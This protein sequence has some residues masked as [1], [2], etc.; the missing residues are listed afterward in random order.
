MEEYQLEQYGPVVFDDSSIEDEPLSDNFSVAYSL[1]STHSGTSTEE[2]GPD[3]PDSRE[4]DS[5]SEESPKAPEP[6]R[7]GEHATS[8]L[9][10]SLKYASR[11]MENQ[12]AVPASIDKCC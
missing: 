9:E 7:K 10:L 4:L 11:K 1:M 12:V 5:S 2:L 8:R 6:S 3:S